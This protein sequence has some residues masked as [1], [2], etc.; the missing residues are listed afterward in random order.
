MGRVEQIRVIR[1][2]CIYTS[3]SGITVRSIIIPVFLGS[4]RLI[5]K[6]KKERIA[7]ERILMQDNLQ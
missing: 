7:F 3:R 4:L 5:V 6:E 2:V 1:Q